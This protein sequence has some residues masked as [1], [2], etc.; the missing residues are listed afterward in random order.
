M[1][2]EALECSERG[3]R[4]CRRAGAE[5]LAPRW[6]GNAGA[7]LARKRWRRAGA[8]TLAPR[9]R[10]NARPESAERMRVEALE[11]SAPR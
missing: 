9:W 2:I 6:R 5:M 7:A 3:E 11:C 1:S 10:G 4:C 8:E